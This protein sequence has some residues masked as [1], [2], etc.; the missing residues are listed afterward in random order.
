MIKWEYVVEQTDDS[1]LQNM[2]NDSAK[3]DL[4]LVALYRIGSARVN[5]IF[6]KEKKE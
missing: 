3:K 6:R 5:V 2:L 4:E 1:N